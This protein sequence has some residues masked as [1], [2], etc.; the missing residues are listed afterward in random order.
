MM[1]LGSG[2]GRIGGG[3][4]RRAAAD[5]IAPSI[6]ATLAVNFG[7]KTLVGYGEADLQYEGGGALT[8]ASGDP[9]GHWQIT[10]RN[11][12]A[13]RNGA[14]AYGSV[15]PAFAG[16]YTLVIT[17]GTVSC[18]LTIN[19]LADAAHLCAVN[20]G[21][22]ADFTYGS[23]V[24]RG[25]Q[26]GGYLNVATAIALGDT[27]WCRSH[28][29]VMTD[30]ATAANG[31]TAPEIRPPLGLYP[32]TGRIT[33][34]SEVADTTGFNG[35]GIAQ[36]RH[37]FRMGKLLVSGA[38]CGAVALPFV[39][40][41]LFFYRTGASVTGPVIQF[42]GGT[43]PFGCDYI[44]NRYENFA[45]TTNA[46]FLLDGIRDTGNA[47]RQ[48]IVE[49]NIF[50]RLGK[51]ITITQG[52][53]IV[54]GNHCNETLEDFIWFAGANLLIEENFAH[55]RQPADDPTAHPDFIQGHSAVFPHSNIIIRR[56]VFARDASFATGLD[57]QFI[58]LDDNPPGVKSLGVEV[59]ENIGIITYG[60]G[61]FL[62]QAVDPIVVRNTVLTDY[63]GQDTITESGLNPARIIAP[64]SAPS[65]RGII[66]NNTASM[67]AL[68]GFV[69]AAPIAPNKTLPL[70]STSAATQASYVV[71]MPAFTTRIGSIPQ[72]LAACAP[73]EL[74]VVDGGLRNPDFTYNGAVLPNGTWNN[75][76][77]YGEPEFP[78]VQ[79]TRF[80]PSGGTAEFAGIPVGLDLNIPYNL[81]RQGFSATGE[82]ITIPTTS[83]VNCQVRT[84]WNNPPGA[85]LTQTLPPN[86]TRT[87][88]TVALS[89]I[90]YVGDSAD[91]VI[92]DST[93]TP[94]KPIVQRLG[95]DHRVT[96]NSVTVAVIAAHFDGRARQQVR[97]VRFRAVQGATTTPWVVASAPTLSARAGWVYQVPEYSATLDVSTLTDA[98]SYRVEYEVIP[99]FGVRNDASPSTDPIHRSW[100]VTDPYRLDDSFVFVKN[101]ARAA[102]PAI[103]VVRPSIGVTAGVLGTVSDPAAARATPFSS[104]STAMAALNTAGDNSG[105][106]IWIA[107]TQ[108]ASW[109]AVS[110]NHRGGALI[111]RRAPSVAVSASILQASAEIRPQLVPTGGYIA[112]I[113]KS[114]L[115]FEDIEVARGPVNSYKSETSA[116]LYVGYSNARFN[117]GTSTGAIIG[118]LGLIPALHFDGVQFLAAPAGSAFLAP[119]AAT[120]KLFHGCSVMSVTSFSHDWHSIV[121]SRFENA[122]NF[123]I[124]AARSQNGNMIYHS[125]LDGLGQ[126]SNNAI[127]LGYSLNATNNAIVNNTTAWIGTINSRIMRISGDS[128]DIGNISHFVVVHNSFV[129]GQASGTH[130]GCNALYD[131]STAGPRF[132]EFVRWQGNIHRSKASK[133]DITFGN[134]A[135]RGN[136][137]Y[138]HGIGAGWNY[139]EAEGGFPCTSNGVF[140]IRPA[141]DGDPALEA[142]F[143]DRRTS[144]A[145]PTAGSLGGN[146][147]LAPD[148]PARAISAP[149]S[150][151]HD[152]DGNVRGVTGAPGAYV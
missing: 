77:V 24:S 142:G 113:S 103:A 40:R 70:L 62:N 138:D 121:G 110:R 84:A 130:G 58:F 68:S 128:P 52:N 95:I 127:Q 136:F 133:A 1:F 61:I 105:C 35:D 145:G 13:P 19:I 102:D 71:S 65:T 18:T 109:G 99:W 73:A 16:P 92:N 56:N 8:I 41:D 97:C 17:D 91:G 30:P 66:I 74:A 55:N 98:A 96:G 43:P 14:G 39:W 125:F 143:I 144:T 33:I 44:N 47:G 87:V 10:G 111:I 120:M 21:P 75:G 28:T 134:A 2:V 49:N 89:D 116:P 72:A 94:P 36:R 32:G 48:I 90:V 151:S 78:P 124:G 131:E 26:F 149:S 15:P 45:T 63:R 4:K 82:P 22:N 101:V 20:T 132:H 86:Y 51:C 115:I 80:E 137:E 117:P 107:E 6:P 3:G 147:H 53:A 25:H 34:R 57:V 104:I 37:G 7:A 42:S 152:L 50:V 123:T 59:Y 81:T 76:E 129:G 150:V 126:N 60:N 114:V 106:Q 79:L 140:S 12:I 69:G 64:D 5:I 118:G 139:Q 119:A 27:I 148:A 31:V 141:A 93:R 112:G 67:L 100:L 38:L 88:N 9:L 108:A 83:Y 135:R 23:P 29:E 146:Y 46:D 122:N 85:N 11:R 54:R